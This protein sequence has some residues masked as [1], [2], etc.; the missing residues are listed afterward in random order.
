MKKNF[1][2]YYA[3]QANL[4]TKIGRKLSRSPKA[5]LDIRLKALIMHDVVYVRL[6]LCKNIIK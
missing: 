3:I 6:L 1:K 4:I 2:M 5:L